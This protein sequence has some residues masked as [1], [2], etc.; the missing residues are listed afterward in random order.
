[1]I[2]E[3]FNMAVDLIS[4]FPTIE[5]LK[6]EPLNKYTHT[7]IGGP[8]DWLAFP[9]SIADTKTLV[10]YA[11]EQNLPLTVL[12]NSSNLI[13]KDG[14]LR[15]LVIMMT[16]LVGITRDGNEISAM[17]GSLTI[18][19]SEYAYQEGLTGLEW[20]AGI[21]G[22]IGGAIYMNAGAYGGETKDVLSK[23]EVLT[24]T[25]EFKTYSLAEAKLG[26]RD[27]VMQHTHDVVLSASF[28]LQPGDKQ[29]IRATMD[30]LNYR[31][32]S[33]Q[34]LELPSA[35]STFKRPV[36][37]FAGKLIMEANLQGFRVGGAEVS[38]KHAGFV[39]N[40]DQATAKDFLAVIEHVQ[41]VVWEKN[42][43]ELE[44]EVRILGED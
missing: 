21:P 9:T 14:G 27:S 1:M 6:D 40:I 43:V 26:Y 23:V 5:I 31:R 8:A 10:D 22:S 2:K 17:A 19:T 29:I 12:G 32:A 39:V 42:H 41:A 44:T 30:D 36:G 28:A 38:T 33:K 11:R 7:K 4:T 37:Y 13:I 24:R 16:K 25:G 18:D 3:G 34:P 15:G 35:G 20:A